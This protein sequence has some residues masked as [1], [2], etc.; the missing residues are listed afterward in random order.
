MKPETQAKLTAL[1]EQNVAA[2]F[3]RGQD[4]FAE[5]LEVDL[6]K[7]EVLNQVQLEGVMDYL[8]QDHLAKKN[9]N[10]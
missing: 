5:S 8:I 1:I 2:G 4:L 7:A 3:V 9:N 6:D 10:A